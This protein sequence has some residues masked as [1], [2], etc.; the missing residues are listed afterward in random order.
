[1]KTEYERIYEDLYEEYHILQAE[2]ERSSFF[3]FIP[4]SRRGRN[5]LIRVVIDACEY[6]MSSTETRDHM[7]SDAKYLLL[8]NLHQMIAS[9]IA[10]SGEMGTKEIGEMLR[11]DAEAIINTA[12]RYSNEREI[13]GHTIISSI[14]NIWQELKSSRLEIWG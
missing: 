1:M 5:R 9:P 7:R 4:M 14:S 3:P 10:I 2:F 6:A 11:H 8:I 12:K 13:S